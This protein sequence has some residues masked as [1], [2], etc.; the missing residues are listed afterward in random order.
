MDWV[1]ARVAKAN[2]ARIAMKVLIFVS[3]VVVNII[4]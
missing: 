3:F 2:N 4:L 1:L